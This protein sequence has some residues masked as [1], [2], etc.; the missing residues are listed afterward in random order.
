MSILLK[1]DCHMF[2]SYFY[3]QDLLISVGSLEFPSGKA[4][5]LDVSKCIGDVRFS[6][7]IIYCNLTI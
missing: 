1:F 7:N 5:V 6:L 3:L 2:V 4:E